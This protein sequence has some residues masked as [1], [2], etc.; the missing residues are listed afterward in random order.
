MLGRHVLENVPSARSCRRQVTLKVLIAGPLCT[1]VYTPEIRAP[2]TQGKGGSCGLD[3]HHSS[4]RPRLPGAKARRQIHSFPA[5]S[6]R[7]PSPNPHSSSPTSQHQTPMHHLPTVP[8]TAGTNSITVSLPRTG[9]DEAV[10]QLHGEQGRMT[11][12]NEPGGESQP[13]TAAPLDC[14]QVGLTT[15]PPLHPPLTCV[16]TR[17]R[18]LR[19][20]R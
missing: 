1:H 13:S 20:S 14:G 12:P 10:A 17:E 2:H 5:R 3:A 19:I 16:C 18:V 8:C 7:R 11:V 15:S 9:D 4:D 6:L